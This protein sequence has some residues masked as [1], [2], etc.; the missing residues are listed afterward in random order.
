MWQQLAVMG[1]NIQLF[2]GIHT[3]YYGP[4]DA[5]EGIRDH[6]IADAR[7]W[8]DIWRHSLTRFW[9][10]LRQWPLISIFS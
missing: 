7:R 10:A 3:H 1:T 9:L 6:A 4:E 2:T 5:H 8:L